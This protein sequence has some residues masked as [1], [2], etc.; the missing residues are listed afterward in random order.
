MSIWFK[1]VVFGLVIVVITALVGLAIFLLTF[2]PN[3]Y[4]DKLEELVF[5]R[6]ERTLTING[7]IGLSLFP[8]IGLSVQ[9]VA[10]SDRG[11]KR[12]FVSVDSA[13]FAVAIWP[14]LS[15][16]LVVDHVAVTGF[17]AWVT[18]DKDGHFN[19]SDLVSKE[20]ALPSLNS[21]GGAGT[22]LAGTLA[23]A[24]VADGRAD[25][26]ID[27]AGLELKSGQIHY[28]DQRTGTSLTLSELN[29]NTG[30]MTYDQAFDVTLKGR[31]L[32]VAPIADAQIEAQA[33]LRLDSNART[34]TAQKINVQL[35]GRLAEL[36]KGVVTLKGNLDYSGTARTFA[37][38]GLELGVQGEWVGPKPVAG[39]KATLSVPQLR[40]DQR[41]SELKVE[42]L[43]L[44]ATGKASG[45]AIDVAFDAPALSIS[46]EAAKGEP[47]TGTVKLTGESTLAV[48]LGLE[49]LSG[50]ADTLQFQALSLDGGI[51]RDKRLLRLQLTSPASWN[52]S[53]KKGELS[54]LKGD[55]SIQDA[56]LPG[57]RFAFPMIGS[58]QLDLVKDQ[59]ETDIN[60]VING[61]QLEFKA[62]AQHLAK[63]KVTFS[64]DA[65]KLDLNN[66]LTPPA[67]PPKA[68][69][70]TD[71]K[72]AADQ[73]ASDS[74]AQAKPVEAAKSAAA[75]PPLTTMDWSLL[76]PL[77]VTGKIKIDDL[78]MRDLQL[79]EVSGN[80]RALGGKLDVSKIAAKLYEG[81]LTGG[82]TA[83]DDQSVTLQ[84]NLDKVAVEPF[85]QALM[86]DGHLSGTGSLQATLEARGATTEALVASLAGKASLQV[87]QGAIR[88][89]DAAKTLQEASEAMR[90]LLEGERATIG[91]PYDMSRRTPFSTLDGRID[92]KNG[93]G[94]LSKLVLVTDLLRV[95]EGKPARVNLP[96]ERLDLQL[97]AQITNKPPKDMA[98]VIGVLRGVTIPVLINGPFQA[99]AYDVQWQSVTN[100]AI[101]DAVKAG[102]AEL[103]TGR[104]LIE[105]AVPDLLPDVLNPQ[106]PQAPQT[107]DDPVKRIG[108]ALKGLL[109][110]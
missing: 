33:L 55:M 29:V 6:Y 16:R 32:G 25:P 13:R 11:G 88:G 4:K 15:N 10:L 95:S 66:W 87:R 44:R 68:K 104:S 14:L 24:A 56:A 77:D 100:K 86:K 98:P 63:P 61:G 43:S 3:A 80:V 92:F 79:R 69:V 106:A 49:G 41:E 21:V 54:A 51:S 58:M 99:L 40:L 52:V 45:Y 27:I 82:V 7:E 72:D 48:A 65:G 84:L 50:N 59:L 46:P 103:L 97:N 108:D 90:G 31:L 28:L 34:Y 107:P 60:A 85:M 89:F 96:D 73:V 23:V 35:A 74:T 8:R 70:A 38:N 67:Q 19:F 101:K 39:L 26:Q 57:G 94:S 30:R 105:K 93:V 37:A 76:T 17:K 62:Q 78:R 12:T 36:D 18:K 91:N 109:G 42:K 47:V 83:R 75:A 110:K 64:L 71:K 102:L 53:L 81:Q 22:A 9:D 5:N 2:N 1:R 20:A